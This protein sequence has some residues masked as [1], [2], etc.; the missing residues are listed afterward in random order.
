MI[1][2]IYHHT[3]I[4]P[5][6]VTYLQAELP[7][8]WTLV[9]CGLQLMH[10]SNIHN[11]DEMRGEQGTLQLSTTAKIRMNQANLYKMQQINEDGKKSVF[12]E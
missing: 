5:K 1:L 12:I 8:F 9:S 11:I 3:G 10:Y 2:W 7:L 6:S 4:T